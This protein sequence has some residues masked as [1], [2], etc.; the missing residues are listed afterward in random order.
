MSYRDI[1]DECYEANLFLPKYKL[2]DL[3]FGNVSVADR[4]RAVF[5]IKPS[6]VDYTTLTESDIVV[7]DFDGQMIRWKSARCSSGATGCLFGSHCTKG[8]RECICA[9]DRR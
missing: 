6:G 8:G 5:A 7:V 3:T 9:R 4:D 2:I 1:K